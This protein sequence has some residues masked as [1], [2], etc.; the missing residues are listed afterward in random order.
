MKAFIDTSALVKYFHEEDGTDIV[1][2]LI[3]NMD[4]EVWISELALVEFAS[5]MHKK[6]RAGVLGKREIALALDG[7]TETCS[8]FFVEPMGQVV[9]QEA[10]AL[11]SKYGKTHNLRT[12]DA[13]QLAAFS[14]IAEP[15]STFVSADINLCAVASLAG[16][17]VMNPAGKH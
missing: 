8:G 1:T 11:L 15:D 14:L 12:L 3:E 5:A 16:Y 2:L 17:P 6:Y 4:N 9:S 10:I 13:L 7:F